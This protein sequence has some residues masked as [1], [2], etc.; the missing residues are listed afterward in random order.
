M[1][2]VARVSIN[3]YRNLRTQQMLVLVLLCTPYTTCFG[4]HLLRTEVSTYIGFFLFALCW[5]ERAPS[6]YVPCVASLQLKNA[7]PRR[8][9]SQSPVWTDVIYIAT[10]PLLA[11]GHPP[12]PFR[13]EMSYR[14]R[15]SG[16]RSSRM[17]RVLTMVHTFQIDGICTLSM[18][19]NCKY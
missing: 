10:A 19:W 13:Q 15:S 14:L 16:G 3:K 2:P 18:V 17:W 6:S 12:P 9:W 11:S 1:H 4:R 7:L 5:N 8:H